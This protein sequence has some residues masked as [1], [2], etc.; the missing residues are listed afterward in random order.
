MG[1]DLTGNI[2]G[3]AGSGGGLPTTPQLTWG[4][5]AAQATLDAAALTANRTFTLPDVGGQ[6]V[7]S[8]YP[9]TNWQDNPAIGAAHIG[10][11]VN[12]YGGAYPTTLTIDDTTFADG[13]FVIVRN[14]R[15]A[16]V[17]MTPQIRD[18]GNI[19]GRPIIAPCGVVVIMCVYPSALMAYGDLVRNTP[20]PITG[21]Y[22]LAWNDQ[23]GGVLS[24]AAGAVTV[25]VPTN[26]SVN[27][28]IST[29][30][31]VRQGAAGKV[32]LASASGVTLNAPF[33]LSTNGVGDARVLEKTATDTWSVY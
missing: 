7:T 9:I 23:F 5:S 1:W 29:I 4:P 22:T 3:P 12:I 6:L 32:T 13:T 27:L 17:S 30:V 2:R 19:R 15:A 18:F 26:A 20:T 16:P 11:V 24:N 33:G 28:P 25:T 21:N 31:P 14:G 8:R 10:G